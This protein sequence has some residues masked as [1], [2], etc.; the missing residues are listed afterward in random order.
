MSDALT[1]IAREQRAQEA[2]DR[3]MRGESKPY[4]QTIQGGEFHKI[5]HEI[6]EL[7]EKKNKAYGSSFAKA[8][9]FL[10]LL[11]P[12]GIKP[13]QYGDMLILVRIFDKQMRIATDRDAFGEDPSQDIAGYAILNI[14]RRLQTA[15]NGEDDE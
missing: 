13:E 4:R 15:A 10:S 12:D 14:N 7:L 6:A 2:Y 3:E 5:A 8:D 1:E 11:Y 9:K